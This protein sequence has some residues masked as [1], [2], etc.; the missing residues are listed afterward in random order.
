MIKDVNN[1]ILHDKISDMDKKLDSFRRLLEIM[2]ELRKGCPWDRKQTID[3][4]RHLTIEETFELSEAIIASDYDD[5]KKELGDLIMHIVFYSKIA[6]ERQLFD[7]SDV[8]DGIC[9]KL[10]IRHPHIFGDLVVKNADDVSNNWEKI[11]LQKE[12]TKSVLAGVPNGLPSLLKA[13]RMQE[14]AAGVGFDWNNVTDVWAKVKEE[15]Q[16]LVYE[17]DNDSEKDKIEEEFGD[18]IF[19]L[20]N[21]ARFIHV[22]PE[23]ALERANKKFKNR[24]TY[25]E[26][27]AREHGRSLLDMTLDEMEED[28]DEAKSLEKKDDII[29]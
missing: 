23:D 1:V 25:I 17:V 29:G 6:E 20:V 4:L 11:K 14:K 7:I 15:M 22:N 10:I 3:S 27:K 16:E 28:W 24:F 9:E 21:Y 12:G 13:Y 19:A 2:D 8:L 26:D 5:V 18:L